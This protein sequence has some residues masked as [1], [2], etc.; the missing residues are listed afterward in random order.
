MENL[1][2]KLAEMIKDEKFQDV[3]IDLSETTLDSIFDEGILIDIPIIG[4]LFGLAKT[5]LTVRDKYKP[6]S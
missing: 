6:S 3:Y 5:T 2:E 4:T 1:S